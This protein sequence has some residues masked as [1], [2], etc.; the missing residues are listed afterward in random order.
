LFRRDEQG[1]VMLLK[2]PQKSW[3]SV[4]SIAQAQGG[5][6]I[7]ALGFPLDQDVVVAVGLITGVDHDG[8]WLTNAGLI[9]GMS[10]GPAFD[11]SGAVVGIVAGG[12]EEAK[13]LDLLIPISFS[14]G[15]RQFI[16][17]PLMNSNSAPT[18]AA[19]SAPGPSVPNLDNPKERD[20][21]YKK[22]SEFLDALPPEQRLKAREFYTRRWLKSSNLT[23]TQLKALLKR[24]DFYHGALNDTFNLALADS[25]I[26]FQKE[27][28]LQPADGIAGE[29]TLAKL[30][31]LARAIEGIRPGE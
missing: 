30:Q 18:V 20:E 10:G 27:N 22:Y 2:L 31:E 16:N 4:K 24:L 8:R 29:H 21:V 5:S 15:L 17:S 25:I 6:V 26:L 7:V 12:Y 23:V 14:T 11:R 1:D 13:A 19:A 9:P 28:N 3:H